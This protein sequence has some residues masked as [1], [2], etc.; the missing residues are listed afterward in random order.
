MDS[1]PHTYTPTV[2]AQLQEQTHTTKSTKAGCAVGNE[3]ADTPMMQYHDPCRAQT[4]AD[5]KTIIIV[6][7]EQTTE[8]AEQLTECIQ[9]TPDQNP[10]LHSG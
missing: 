5:G 6:N 3:W 9:H 7:T 4:I 10:L 1:D 8:Y 2:Q